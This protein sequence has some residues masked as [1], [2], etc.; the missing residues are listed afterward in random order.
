MVPSEGREFPLQDEPFGPFHPWR[1]TIVGPRVASQPI[2]YVWA[3]CTEGPVGCQT[4]PF[5]RL[6]LFQNLS[7]LILKTVIQAFQT[8][9]KNQEMNSLFL[10]RKWNREIIRDF[11]A[12]SGLPI[13][14]RFAWHGGDE[15]TTTRKLW[16]K[17]FLPE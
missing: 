5:T 9:T 11:G 4:C 17:H 3:W 7:N 14:S 12:P 16:I 6:R 8:W 10:N 15:S 1:W 2:R 13:P